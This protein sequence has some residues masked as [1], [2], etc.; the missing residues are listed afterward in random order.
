MKKI[1]ILLLGL[2]IFTAC[3]NPNQKY[4]SIVSITPH[5]AV[6]VDKFTELSNN[7]DEASYIEFMRQGYITADSIMA[8]NGSEFP[9]VGDVYLIITTK[10]FLN[11]IKDNPVKVIK[12][13]EDYI[14]EV[15]IYKVH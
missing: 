12:Y 15:T 8:E 7:I 10:R 14:G 1:L 4:Q 3:T 9:M 11:N 5:G 13:P 2:V 6:V